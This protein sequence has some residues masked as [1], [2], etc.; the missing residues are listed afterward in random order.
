MTDKTLITMI[1]RTWHLCCDSYAAG[2][3][4]LM[5]DSIY[6]QRS[7]PFLALDDKTQSRHIA[8]VKKMLGY[9][10]GNRTLRVPFDGQAPEILEQIRES[11]LRDSTAMEDFYNLIK[12]GLT[13]DKNYTIL[14]YHSVYDIPCKGTDGA[15][16]Q[17][18]EE[19]YD[20]ILCLICP[21][22]KSKENLCAE[23][24]KITLTIPDMVIGAPA[25][26]FL[27]PAF[28]EGS[29]DPGSA[30][31]YNADAKCVPHRLYQDALRMAPFQ[32][33]SELRANLRDTAGDCWEDLLKIT[34]ALGTKAPDQQI[35]RQTFA[36]ILQALP[37]ER[38]DKIL[39]GY[40]RYLEP[41]NP[42]AVQL[43][44]PECAAALASHKAAGRKQW[45][46]RQAAVALQ[47]IAPALSEE[48]QR[49]ADLQGGEEWEE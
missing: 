46:F 32:T 5:E 47:E 15:D 43:I 29:P 45:L 12:T 18:S 8:L 35:D 4:P 21:T 25:A 39:K 28:A 14:I 6:Q 1:K 7:A 13:P 22:K 37:A 26:G 9:D 49:E 31:I 3:L 20:F 30:V 24:E 40:E 34:A 44:I 38:A 42:T 10:I 27:W 16:Q 19:V 2:Y 48:L 17:E 23:E 41:Y 36:E 11:R 33:T